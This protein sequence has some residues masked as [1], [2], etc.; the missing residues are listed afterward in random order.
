M[1]SEL[2]FR[3]HLILREQRELYDYWRSCAGTR[4]FPSRADIDPV[5]IPHLLPGL[6]ILDAIEF[7]RAIRYRLAGT[8]VCQIFGGDVTGCD[9]TELGSTAKHSYWR[10]VYRK[11]IDERMPMQ[12]VLRA[13]V[14]HRNATLLFWLRLPLGGEGVEKILGY[15]ADLSPSSAL[16]ELSAHGREEWSQ[17]GFP[18]LRALIGKG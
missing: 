3:A 16:M 2:A 13:P 12:G 17:A 14:S 6:S 7:P 4:A 11:V 9:V 15:D 8:R 5:A 1:A 10:A 18:S